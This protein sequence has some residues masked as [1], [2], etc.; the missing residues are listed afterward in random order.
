[1][2]VGYVVEVVVG[3]VGVV[4]DDVYVVFCGGRFEWCV[5]C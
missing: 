3:V 1:M 5:C 4:C 2:V